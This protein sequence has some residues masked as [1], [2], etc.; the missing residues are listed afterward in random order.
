MKNIPSYA[1]IGIL[2]FLFYLIY[3]IYFAI[4]H[5]IPSPG[6]SW[7][8]HIPIAQT[9]LSGSFLNLPHAKLPQWY[10]PGSSEAINALFIL[11]H[12]PLTLSN[13]F[14][15]VVLFFSLTKLGKTFKLDKFYSLLF[16]LAICTTNL[17][18]RWLN[19]VSID[20]WVGVFF[21]L[22]IVLLEKPHKYPSYFF[23]LGFIAGM[24][25]GSKYTSLFFIIIL[26]ILYFKTIVVN[27]NLKNFIAFFLPFSILGL[28]WY[29]RNYFLTGN[30]IYPL[31]FLFFKGQNLFTDNILHITL[32][33]PVQMINAGFG[34]Y[35][36]WILS[37]FIAF[38]WVV[39]KLI[40]H[41][42]HIDNV[43]K[44]FLLGLCNFTGFLSFPTSNQTWI[45]VSSF[46]YSLPIF[47][48]LILG[49][50]LMANN[51]KQKNLLGIFTIANMLDVLSM[52]YYPKLI[53]FYLP[54][55]LLVIFWL[56]RGN[57]RK[58]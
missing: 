33:Y 12:I 52:A 38:G 32:R 11:L 19:A 45:M 9:I 54:L 8:Y 51:H 26:F 14:A 42:F 57:T 3:Y 41:Q 48:P 46:R 21:T 29:I 37:L 55:A 20:I 13:I 47:I 17:V 27:L 49:V 16:A 35:K 53:L 15:T 22:A 18:L 6:D 31:P 2:I 58:I 30:P 43:I 1:N 28:F 7:D 56:N 4:L 25:I 44:L 36:L 50:F 34:E 40:K 24:L 10:Y 39:F 23:K 5:P